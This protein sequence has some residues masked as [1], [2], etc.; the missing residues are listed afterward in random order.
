VLSV[1]RPTY[2]IAILRLDRDHVIAATHGKR[3]IDN[4]KQFKPYLKEHHL[5][6]EVQVFEES[7]LAFADEYQ[8]T[9]KRRSS[10]A[11]SVA[12]ASSVP[13]S[14]TSSISSRAGSIVSSRRS[15]VYSTNS[16]VSGASGCDFGFGRSMFGMT[17]MPRPE[18]VT[19]EELQED[20][21]GAWDLEEELVD[22]S[23]KI[24]PGVRRVI[25]SIP[26][27]R[28]CVATSG[29]KTYG[30]LHGPRHPSF[31]LANVPYLVCS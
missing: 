31:G 9:Q 30:E 24:L 6:G 21:E 7:I 12:S 17:P 22:R 27:G 15:S 23:V 1:V 20:I 4:L 25:D 28:Y 26:E 29:A 14:A 2:A 11:S 10:R 5:P 3:A 16:G 8:D 18:S 13:M 19:Y